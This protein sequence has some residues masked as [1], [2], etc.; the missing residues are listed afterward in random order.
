[1]TRGIVR[2]ATAL[3]ASSDGQRRVRAFDEDEFTLAAAAIE[4]LAADHA[5][6]AETS[7]LRFG[8]AATIPA[9]S[10]RGATGLAV[11]DDPAP[12]VRFSEALGA[13]G[14]ASGPQIVLGVCVD[15]SGGVGVPPPGE[16]GFAV[17]V[18]ELPAGR[19]G[20]LEADFSP[21]PGEELSA[22][23]GRAVKAAAH[24]PS[25]WPGTWAAPVGDGARPRGPP[26]TGAPP[27]PRVSE[28]AYVPL[29][30][31]QD[32]VT[33]RWRFEGER[34]ARCG[35]ITFPA[36]GRCRRCRAE[37]S[38][39]TVRLP[40]HGLRVA[41]L[42]WIGPGGQPTEFDDQVAATGPYGVALVE[43]A[44]GIRATVQLAEVD[45]AGLGV[46]SRLDTRLRRLYAIDGAWRYGRKG[47]A[48]DPG[49][50]VP[51]R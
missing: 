5:L 4:V 36:R 14:A 27:P 46:G 7:V 44:D 6:P 51:P 8:T 49:A 31:Y 39:G 21:E 9:G 10:L 33:S 13:A 3:A 26:P 34:C 37:E 17:W 16:G 25:A 42:T 41:A 28:G 11:P 40:R 15:L 48:A 29:P 47:V 43:L 2:V 22:L 32:G 30:S 50:R 23:F 24:D 20:L 45:P 19:P 1:M 18:D 38:L 35:T 12:P